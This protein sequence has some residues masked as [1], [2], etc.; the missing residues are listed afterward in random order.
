MKAIIDDF[1]V[2]ASMIAIANYPK[3]QAELDLMKAGSVIVRKEFK[4]KYR[5]TTKPGFYSNGEVDQVWA[6]LNGL[7]DEAQPS[8]IRRRHSRYYGART[9]YI[10]DEKLV[11]FVNLIIPDFI[12][13]IESVEVIT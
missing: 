9:F 4:F 11:E 2:H 1:G 7:G 5:V 6:Y 10:N 8:K 3:N 13:K 12:Q